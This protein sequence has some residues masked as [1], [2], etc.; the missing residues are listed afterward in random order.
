MYHN[1]SKYPQTIAIIGVGRWGQNLLREFNKLAKV[2][3]CCTTGNEK[4][5]K[6]IKENYPEIICTTNIDQILKDDEVKA[7]IVATP[8]NS[9]FEL[10]TKVLN[11][12]KHVFVEKPVASSAEDIEKL[13]SLAKDKN[14][15]L[16]TDHI[17]IH[18]P[19]YKYLSEI[20]N[21]DEIIYMRFDQKKWGTFDDGIFINL[22]IH[23][24]YIMLTLLGKIKSV[25]LVESV[26]VI[27]NIDIT[28]FN[29]KFEGGSNVM[30]L[31]NR[32]SVQKINSI[33]IKTKD[34]DYIWDDIELFEIDKISK[35]TTSIFKAEKSPLEEVCQD[36]LDQLQS[37]DRN[38]KDCEV[39]VES[40]KVISDLE[41]Q[42]L[43]F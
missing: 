29:V 7:V 30:V 3:Y 35:I 23:Q 37:E 2:K 5:L 32:A 40:L 20:V 43:E 14:L 16:F 36:F 15:M 10:A 18:N 4:N 26:P 1:M 25:K 21:S 22:A 8:I 24:V 12:G 13:I 9:H 19:I 28:T 17:F 6:S 27:S 39:A 11:A 42:A 41:K 31:I 34:K 33:F 38:Y